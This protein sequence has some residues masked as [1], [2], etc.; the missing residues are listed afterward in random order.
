MSAWCHGS[1]LALGQAGNLDHW[2][3]LGF[4]ELADAG[5]D[6]GPGFTGALKEPGI[7]STAWDHRDHL[8]LRES[9]DTRLRGGS[10]FAGSYR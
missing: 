8:G 2:I 10:G 1:Q 9:K 4:Q 5:V 3:C 6:W 7:Y